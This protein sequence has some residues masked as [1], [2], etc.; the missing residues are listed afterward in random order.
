MKHVFLAGAFASLC[1]LGTLAA[2]SSATPWQEPAPSATI[3][4]CLLSG[5][6]AG[7]FIVSTGR[8]RLTAMAEQGVDLAAHVN[9]RVRLTGALE[10]AHVGEVFRVTALTLVATTCAAD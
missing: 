4:G 8:E 5:S 1:G 2:I 10:V 3:E 6:A 9:H 7:E